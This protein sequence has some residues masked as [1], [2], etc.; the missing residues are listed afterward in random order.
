M[1]LLLT[2]FEL[3]ASFHDSLDWVCRTQS[4]PGQAWS[5]LHVLPYNHLDL[6]GGAAF[7]A[8]KL[9][10]HQQNQS[11][12]P[13]SHPN[14]KAAIAAL[15]GFEVGEA[16]RGCSPASQ[17]LLWACHA[18][19]YLCVHLTLSLDVSCKTTSRFC[20][21]SQGQFEMCLYTLDLHELLMQCLPG[22]ALRPRSLDW[23]VVKAIL[24]YNSYRTLGP[25]HPT[26]QEQTDKVCNESLRAWLTPYDTA[27]K[28]AEQHH[29]NHEQ[30]QHAKRHA[31]KIS[32]HDFHDPISTPCTR[33]LFVGPCKGILWQHEVWLRAMFHLWG[34]HFNSNYSL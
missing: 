17:T 31:G 18:W 32:D 34:I 19:A 1:T 20:H 28:L 29:L 16:A 3:T 24:E 11:G 30:K 7:A 26:F 33:S 12:N 13:V 6:A 4:L 8:F 27:E 15:A 5:Q 9:Y 14:A 25:F 22:L 21:Y 2:I 10:E 23:T